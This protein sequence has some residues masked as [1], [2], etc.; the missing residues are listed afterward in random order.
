MTHDPVDSDIV[1]LRVETATEEDADALARIELSSALAGYAHIFPESM[2]KPTLRHLQGRWE[3]FLAD[4]I[5]TVLMAKVAE[6][7]VGFVSY[8][9]SSEAVVAD[10]VLRKLYV[11]PDHGRQGIGSQ[12]HDRAVS[13]LSAM[14]CTTAH[15][16]VLERNIVA[17]RMYVSRG[18]KLRPLSKSPW[19]GS[20]IL[21]LCY[22]RELATRL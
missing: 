12:L 19:P 2:A 21:E 4:P 11:V 22:T 13:G 3:G 1:D 16:W 10:G 9:I 7:P 5:L 20:G 15:L 17:R 6:Q 14:G 8:G 18:W